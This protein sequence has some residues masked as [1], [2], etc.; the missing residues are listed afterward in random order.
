MFLQQTEFV[1]CPLCNKNRYKKKYK[2]ETWQ[3]VQCRHCSLVYVN[4]RLKKTELLRLY[5]ENYFDN[6]SVGYYH[7]TE[8]KH[9]RKKNFHKWLTDALPFIN[10]N[11]NVKALDI[12]CAAGYCLEIFKCFGWESFGIELDSNLTNT[13]K[14]KG[15]TV[16]NEPLQQL[17][18]ISKFSVITMFDVIEHLTDLQE[19]MKK[20]N[21][22]LQDD[23]ILIMVT[24]DYSSFQRK[25]FRKNWFQFKPVEHINYFTIDTLRHLA[26]IHGFEIIKSKKAGQFCDVSF[27]KNRLKKYRLHF[28]LPIF[29]IF[30]K[31]LFLKDRVVYMDTASLYLVMRKKATD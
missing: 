16:Y 5:E 14:T 11:S 26:N 13:L 27:L 22:L 8:N 12:G 23:G 7:Y 18:D 28:L 29:G 15:F 17:T 31:L 21:S 4:P 24:P 2:I 20:L 1:N 6:V 25:I 3:I 9:L 10:T 30:V 19:N